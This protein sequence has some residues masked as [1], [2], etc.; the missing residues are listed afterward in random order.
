MTNRKKI[1][2]A[3]AD[4]PWTTP[5]ALVGHTG[6]ARTI[7]YRELELMVNDGVAIRKA[8]EGGG[9]AG[10]CYAMVGTGVAKQGHVYMH[11]DKRVLA[12]ET[13]VSVKVAE[14]VPEDECWPVR[15]HYVCNANA[16]RPL[17][18]RYFHGQVAG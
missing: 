9:H 13:G 7:V 1:A 12:L 3:L 18:M 14:I 5:L 17:P 8:R 4:H 2:D 16:L 6:I 11:K 15:S 10:Y